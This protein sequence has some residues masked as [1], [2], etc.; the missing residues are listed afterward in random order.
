MI[1]KFKYGIIK[2]THHHSIELFDEAVPLHL[3]DEW[4]KIWK[5]CRE[6]FFHEW[7]RINHRNDRYYS[8][9]FYYINLRK[10]GI[11]LIF[12]LY[13]FIYFFHLVIAAITINFLRKKNHSSIP[14]ISASLSSYAFHFSFRAIFRIVRKRKET[15]WNKFRWYRSFAF[16]INGKLLYARKWN[17]RWR[18]YL[19][20]H[21]YINDCVNISTKFTFLYLHCSYSS[22][23]E[24]EK[25]KR[26]LHLINVCKWKCC[27]YN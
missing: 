15:A 8:M 20:N 10:K 13:C 24:V 27:G 22:I 25:R 21:S 16:A 18:K 6:N 26:H 14:F 17:H 5:K 4:I 7:R 23:N 9:L 3:K 1:I 12:L 19:R 11:L 2:F